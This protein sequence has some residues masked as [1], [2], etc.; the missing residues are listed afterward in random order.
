M[1]SQAAHHEDQPLYWALLGRAFVGNGNFT[2]AEVAGRRAV[3][4][5]PHSS[6]TQITLLLAL[7]GQRR[8][9][10]AVDLAWL[11]LRSAPG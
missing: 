3:A 4:L 10:E 8:S 9:D 1:E 5:E 6:G 2:D 7:L 11:I